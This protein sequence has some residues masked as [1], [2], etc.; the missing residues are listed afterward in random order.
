M[1]N[2][3]RK[4]RAVQGATVLGVDTEVYLD[5]RLFGKPPDPGQARR[6]LERLS[7][8]THEVFSG[9]VLIHEGIEHSGTARTEVT[10][11][12]LDAPLIEWYLTS[13]EWRDRAGG[14]AVQGRGAALIAS[15]D[16]DY[17]NVVGLP[18]ALLLDLAPWLLE[19]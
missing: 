3:R 15:I 6:Y 10:F 17:W 5:G 4:A 13:G 19:P 9:L 11:R 16:G 8:R 7:G 18:V 2:A 12:E 14:Y 1:R